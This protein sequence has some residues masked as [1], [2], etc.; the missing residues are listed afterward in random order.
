VH[1]HGTAQRRDRACQGTR[2]NPAGHPALPGH[3]AHQKS[4]TGF[5]K[6]LAFEKPHE[7]RSDQH[8]HF[9]RPFH[10]G[11]LSYGK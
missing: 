10:S 4:M 5:L 7:L 1:Q 3:G 6:G 2:E 9:N 11:I 8:E